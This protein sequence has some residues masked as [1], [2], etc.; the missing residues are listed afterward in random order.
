MFSQNNNKSIGIDTIVAEI[1]KCSFDTIS[2][3]ILTI[4]NTISHTGIYPESWGSGVIVPI[5]KG[6]DSG[7]AKNYRDITLINTIAKIYTQ[8]LLSRL[9]RWSTAH[10][11]LTDN[12]FGFQK[13]KSTIDCIFLLH[14]IIQKT[15]NSRKK[16]NCAHIDLEKCF[17][18]FNRYL[19][20]QKLVNEDVSQKFIVASYV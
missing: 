6:G 1:Y 9:T 10:E 20:F 7:N 18:K 16:L 15:L 2:P 13:R 14:S 5:F 4:F 8:I 3:F 19:I 11:I 12:Q 17:D